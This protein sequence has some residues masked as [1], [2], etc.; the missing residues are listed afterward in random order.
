VAAESYRVPDNNPNW[1]KATDGFVAITKRHSPRSPPLSL[2]ES[3]QGYVIARWG[4]LRVVG[5]YAPPNRTRPVFERQLREVGDGMRRCRLHPVLV[6]GDFNAWA[7]AWGSRLTNGRGRFLLSWAAELDLQ[8]LNRWSK[9]TCVRTQ[10]QSIV[11][12]TW[13]T[14]LA[15][16]LVSS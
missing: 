8:L 12:L 9:S 14:P 6:A 15:V 13:A 2:I 4:A 5:V 3:G 1:V 7:V 11:N 10:G 16:R